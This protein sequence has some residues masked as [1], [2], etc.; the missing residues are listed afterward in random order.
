MP[1]KIL[2]KLPVTSLLLGLHVLEQDVEAR[3]LV[4]FGLIQREGKAYQAQRRG[5]Q[6]EQA[7]LPAL[8]KALAKGGRL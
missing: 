1:R 5:S 4:G 2:T 3:L 8:P 6:A 7:N